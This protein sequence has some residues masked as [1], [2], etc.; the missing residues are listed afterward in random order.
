[1]S[2]HPTLVIAM[3]FAAMSFSAVVRA[4]EPA[5]PDAR[6]LS[7]K[8]WT[9][10]EAMAQVRLNPEDVY[11]QYVALQLAKSQNKADEVANIIEQLRWRNRWGGPG[12]DRRVDL[13][14]LFTGALAVQESLQL[15]TM[16]GRTSD[17]VTG[18]KAETEA[19]T[20]KISEL[21][22]PK[23]ESH[24]WGKM[25]AVQQL[26]GKKPEIGRLDLCVPGDQYYI[27]FRSLT[28]L[29]E[30]IDAGDLWGAHLYN[31]AAKCAQTQRTSDR[32][33]AQLAIQ[34]DPLTR[35]FYDMVVEEAAITG[36]DLY[37]R[38]GSDV[39]MLFLVKQPQVLRARMDG[40]LDAAAKSR[41]DAVRSTGKIGEV[42]YAAVTTPD[43]AIHAF[44]AYP[45]P[46]LHV[47]SN[48]KHGLE[49]V[50]AAVAGDKDVGRLGESAEFRYI[51]TLM[52]RG[53][54]EEDG[55]VY[56][57]DP[58]IRKLV[59]PELKLT[60][61]R[62]MICYN[63]L[64]MIGHA[65]MLYR[66]Q[67]GVEPKSIDELV[68]GGC[69]PV[70]FGVNLDGKLRTEAIRCPC[71][72]KYTL[73]AD[74]TTGVC[75]HHG[76]ALE[77]VP[78]CEIALDAVTG[79]E[80]DEY[81]QFVADYS[82]YWRR[83]FDPIAIRVQITPKRY[84]AETIILPLI[85][86]SIYTGLAMA[87]GGE[88]EPLD[89]LPVPKKNIFT[90]VARLNKEEL[91][92]Q[93]TPTYGM[94]HDIAQQGLPQGPGTVSLE[95]FVAK[96][97]GNQI[98]MNVYDASPMFD[99]NLTGFLGEMVG[100]FRGIGRADPE[101]VPISFLIASLNSPVYL[102][103]PV[104]DEKIVD[105]FLDGLDATLGALARQQQRNMFPP[106]DYDFYRVG[107]KDKGQ[108]PTRCYSVRFGPIKWRAFF[109]RIDKALYIASQ[110]FI[111]DDL[112]AAET[113]TQAAGETT[114]PTAHGMVR[115]RARHWKDALPA[116]Q[117]GWAEGSRDACLNNLSPL[118]S[119]A[120][121]LTV[122]QARVL[123][124]DVSREADRLYGAH[125]FCPDG[126]KYEITPDGKQVYCSLHGTA[127][128]PRQL[129]APASDSPMGQV[130]KSFGGL[131]AEL[132][133]LEDGLHA[134]VTIERK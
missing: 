69:A 127:I 46:D 53:A 59:G 11:L 9:L 42:E 28:K 124:A 88:P 58:F 73:S 118:S 54:K 17:R 131:T 4:D 83:F 57:S 81:K 95:E 30:G 63:Y 71:G 44:S 40:F 25:L 129:I 70:A 78:C 55:L 117:L 18:N 7:P 112:A 6:I 108:G 15:D 14:D 102:A 110:R 116:F 114:G 130:L 5:M 60:E 3:L 92:K 31:Q 47:R 34:T 64:R 35:P 94:F 105:K 66:T 13:F 82:Q 91:L 21:A 75:S 122:Q 87:L 133:F 125:A 61:R 90:M 39:T 65:A 89:A 134:V 56:L 72:G 113:S 37:F 96:G 86:N 23:V 77:L 85:D 10:D 16:R 50:L 74:G 107:S 26:A 2:R 52:P 99:F 19:T 33:K 101:L 109:A 119:V 128:A 62:R 8:A 120:R 67:F 22:G 27:A 36:S 132:T 43:R 68:K 106:L 38:E 123:P 80:A 29:L 32:L 51:R 49:R 20:V 111:L 84:R 126:G 100:A 41:P 48:S 104:K 115:I 12:A 103:L 121:A 24:P 1:M 97:L 45:K 93:G 79:P 76:S 98:S